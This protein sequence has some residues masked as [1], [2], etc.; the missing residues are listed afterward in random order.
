MAI[1]N[2]TDTGSRRDVAYTP[3]G[4]SSHEYAHQYSIT[5]DIRSNGLKKHYTWLLCVVLRR[6]RYTGVEGKR[7]FVWK[8]L[9]ITNYNRAMGLKLCM[10]R[11]NTR[12]CL[13]SSH[14]R[15]LAN[16]INY[17]PPS[18]AFAPPFVCNSKARPWFAARQSSRAFIF[19]VEKVLKQ[20][21]THTVGGGTPMKTHINHERKNYDG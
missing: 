20:F 13:E 6:M 15:R 21:V 11:A 1:A 8:R 18:R 19:N 17:D 10:K 7:K 5:G 2:I 9:C 4:R 14:E 3:P 12:L 16:A